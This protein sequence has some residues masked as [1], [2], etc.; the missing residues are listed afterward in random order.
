[1]NS[2]IEY[3]SV[4]GKDMSV[5][6]KGEKI[7]QSFGAFTLLDQIDLEII[8]GEKIGIVGHNGCGKSTLLEM[9]AGHL[10]PS[11]GSFHWYK[12]CAIAYMPQ[13]T[14]TND[15]AVLSGGERTKKRLREVLYE[16]HQLLILDEPTNHLDQDSIKWLIKEIQKEK[17]TLVVVSHD[18]Y[19]LD[20]CATRIIEIDEGK[21]K[22]YPGNYSF[23]Q[24]EKQAQ[25]ASQ[26]HAYENQ[27]KRKQK[28]EE[29]IQNLK[30]WSQ[31]AHNEA[32]A[33]AIETGNKFGGKEHNRAK[34]KKRDKQVASK[35]KRLT[36]MLQEGVEKPKAEQKITFTLQE[37]PKANKRVIEAQN[38]AKS[39][40]KKCL[41]EKSSFYIKRG[42]KIGLFG[43]NGCGKSTLVKA[44]MGEVALE[45]ELFLSSG[46]KIGY[47]SQEVT[48]MN[49][50]LTVGAYLEIESQEAIR[51]A[52]EKL[53][54]MGFIREA[55]NQT[56][57]TFSR[58]QQMKLKLLKM[59]LQSC[60]LLILD[61]PTNHMD[62]AVRETLEEVLV[63]YNG[64]LLLI[65]HDRYMLEKLCDHLLIFKNQ[66]ITRFEGTLCEYED[67]QLTQSKPNKKEREL[68]RLRIEH[69][70]AYWIGELS[71]YQ[72]GSEAYRKAE[73]EY[74]KLLMEKRNL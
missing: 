36:A 50:E 63:S 69:Q 47:M 71:A 3:P 43:P 38:I 48:D 65:T 62:L 42:E 59:I 21:L 1:M 7:T 16:K 35:I 55:F 33:K 67:K 74:E 61:E 72:A 68:Q 51:C 39:Y 70:L 32:R 41:F 27:E 73:A 4:N 10:L 26:L 60:Q 30:G 40:G 66:R 58:G 18:R 17:G 54:Q 15:E 28:I 49:P 13:V 64:T 25:R 29:E 14:E 23:Y 22:S 5:L 53:A 11:E 2:L 37:S 12:S 44:L 24:K 57:G 45:G 20:Q 56:I 31:K 8:E 9:I 6:L 52:R 46:I 34:A 19:F